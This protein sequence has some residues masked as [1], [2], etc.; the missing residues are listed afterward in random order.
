MA[1]AILGVYFLPVRYTVVRKYLVC[2]LAGIGLLP[3][4]VFADFD[5][6]WENTGD[7]SE[8]LFAG[9][10]RD[11]GIIADARK[12]DQVALDWPPRLSLV[13]GG[14]GFPRYEP[15]AQQITLPY[16]YL[17]QAT[18][19]Q[20]NFESSRTAA[21]QRG[22][23]VVEYTL[24]HLLGHAL[25]GSHDVDADP[26]AERLATWLMASQYVNGGEQWLEAV[27]AFGRA[28][29]RLD[30]PLDDYWHGHGLSK[31]GAKRLNCLV[32]GQAPE[33]YAERFPGLSE[34]PEKVAACVADWASLQRSTET[35]RAQE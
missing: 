1:T 30:G 21:L 18:R 22:L 35:P 8:A 12:L 9:A 7:G 28:S 24:Y 14:H 4:V 31:A 32:V 19:A 29:Q 3:A 25:L 2:C 13:L 27:E 26:Q 15:R 23:D 20:A 17:A 11:S 34:S 6:R 33:R 5:V 16:E 10:L